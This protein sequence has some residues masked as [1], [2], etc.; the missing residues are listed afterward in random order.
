MDTSTIYED[1]PPIDYHPSFCH[2]YYFLI[3]SWSYCIQQTRCTPAYYY[4]S[5]KRRDRLRLDD[6]TQELSVRF[7]LLCRDDH[8][9][10]E[11]TNSESADDGILTGLLAGPLI[12]ASLLYLTIQAINTGKSLIP[13]TWLIEAPMVLKHS[14]APY[15]AVEALLFSRRNLVN[16]AT[17]CSTIVI[18]HVLSSWV[19]EARHR[20]KTVVPNG[21]LSH[22]PRREGRRTYLYIL[23]I[24]SVTLW[25]LCVK[26]ALQEL[27]LG[28]WQSTCFTN[29]HSGVRTDRLFT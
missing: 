1:G 11:L 12:T 9:D 10:P 19:T 13:S 25:N 2:Y 8:I 16:Q 21:E 14:I 6:G 4:F 7:R 28:I 29:S 20:R 3:L 15:T 5:Q 27:K 22:V 26:I 23:F 24:V 18:V 17:F